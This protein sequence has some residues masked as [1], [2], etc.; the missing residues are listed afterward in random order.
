MA[1]SDNYLHVTERHWEKFIGKGLCEAFLNTYDAPHLSSEK[2]VRASLK[3]D[4][5][6]KNI[7]STD[8]TQFTDREKWL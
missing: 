7:S 4:L 5:T 2:T 6:R 3:Y 8:S 1:A